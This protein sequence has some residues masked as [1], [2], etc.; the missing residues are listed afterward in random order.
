MTYRLVER[1][2][3]IRTTG[4]VAASGIDL[5]GADRWSVQSVITF[6]GTTTPGIRLDFKKSN[7]NVNF[8]TV[9][10]SGVNSSGTLW[11]ED[12]RPTYRYGQISV[13]STAGGTVVQNYILVGGEGE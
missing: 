13:S 4:P 11:F 8:S 2:M 3:D 10:S 12:V 5:D 1:R 6:T 9:Q 7:D